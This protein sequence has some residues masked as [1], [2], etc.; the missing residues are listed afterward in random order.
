MNILLYPIIIPVVFGIFCFVVPKK[1]RGIALIGSLITFALTIYMFFQGPL[2]L[3][4]DGSLIF[5]LDNLSRFILMASTLFGVLIV[6]Y[7]F[8]FM[9]RFTR[10]SEYYAYTLWTVSF[11]CGAILSNS[12]VWLLIFWTLLA[13]T[14]FLLIDIGGPEARR[15][16]KKTLIIVGGSD[17]VMILGVGAL[18]IITKKLQMDEINVPVT[19]GLTMV[20]FLCLAITAFTK[21]GAM[22][23]HTWIPDC[24]EKAPIPVTAFL[25]ASVDKLLGIYLLARIALDLFVLN[26]AASLV[27]LIVGSVTIVG[28]VLFAIIQHDF[29][30][31]L[32]Y[33]A[34]SQVGYMVLGIGT[35][36]PIGIAG[37]IFHMLN[38]AIYKG[39]LFLCGG[40]VE[41]RVGTTQLKKLGG[42][43]RKMP[44]TLITCVISALAISGIPPMNGFVSKWMVFQGC[45]ILGQNGDKLWLIWLLAA[46]LGSALTLFSFMKFIHGTFFGSKEKEEFKDVKE[47]NF[48]MWIPMV[49]LALL[50]IVFG[51]FA[52]QFPLKYFIGPAIR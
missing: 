25:P 46:V 18:W 11:A 9:E 22:P 41:H 24:A 42:L 15:A 47:V 36:N 5:R 48:T 30:V 50:C 16:A 21:A 6:L 33:H 44:I 20:A 19:G 34:V 38:H 39:C 8:K 28:A 26:R 10:I 31:L 27:L 3:V 51:I 45:A 32:S 37:G 40:A 52:F 23:F 2:S 7:S 13:I 1:L 14:L 4:K 29:K 35:G 43:A 17:V 49:V 12:L